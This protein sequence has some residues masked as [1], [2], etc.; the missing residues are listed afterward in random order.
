M[1]VTEVY[2]EE[3]RGQILQAMD[4]SKEIEDEEIKELIGEYI[5]RE[6]KFKFLTVE[7]RVTL[8][9]EVFWSLRGWDILQKAL[10]DEEVTEVMVN[11]MESI[12]V[13]KAGRIVKYGE[14]FTA[15]E[16]LRDLIQRVAAGCNRTI[17]EAM[18]ILD[19]RLSSGGRVNVVLNPVALNG[20]I[21]TIRRFPK[22]PITMEGLIER[23]SLT[24]EVAEY[25]KDL[26]EAGYNI[27]VSGGTG[28]GKTTMLNVL[29]QY[30]P[31]DERVITIEDSAELQIQGVSNLVKLE[32]RNA[33]MEGCLAISIRD[34]IKTA[35][36]MRPDRII[37]GEVRGGEAIDM[38]Q[39]LNTGHDGSMSTGHANSAKD[40]I[41][42]LET[43]ILM[44]M[45]I[46]LSAVRKQI[47]SGLDI[48]VHLGRLRD[49]TR[50]VLEICEVE[51]FQDGEVLLHTLFAFEEEGEDENGRVI[52]RLCARGEL[53][54]DGKLKAHGICV[55][56]G[57]GGDSDPGDG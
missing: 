4:Y 41:S 21:I 38:M 12:F 17:N 35:L 40:M 2:K 3:L 13:E 32:S 43:M 53:I 36:R 44:G 10:D 11:G 5:G 8:E 42:R 27:F 24:R 47:A 7:E 14:V 45:E 28:S 48:I 50:R 51:G 15:E 46:P 22:N 6:V 57:S 52:G 23:E 49:K 18:P 9:K 37:V 30:I 25:L 29:S 19:A 39:C 34:L 56:I 33:N 31:K 20:P 55:S 54:H 16:K 1:M 26:V